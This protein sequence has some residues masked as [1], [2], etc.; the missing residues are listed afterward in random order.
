MPTLSNLCCDDEGS[1]EMLHEGSQVQ[2]SLRTPA[3]ESGMCMREECGHTVSNALSTSEGGNEI[4]G[5]MAKS[6]YRQHQF[7]TTHEC[8]R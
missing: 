3:I 1:L 2:N 6:V 8:F 7:I 5:C 4:T